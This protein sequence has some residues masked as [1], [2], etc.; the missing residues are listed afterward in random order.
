MAVLQS[1]L[2]LL[3]RFFSI[4]LV[5]PSVH[6]LLQ[7]LSQLALECVWRIYKTNRH[8]ILTQMEDGCLIPI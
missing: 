2:I 6:Q 3:I 1:T 7:Q 8:F 5:S 4:R